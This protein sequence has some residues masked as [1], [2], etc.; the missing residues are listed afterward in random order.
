MWFT[1]AVPPGQSPEAVVSELSAQA[2]GLPAL[3]L[4]AVKKYKLA[5]VLDV[6]EEGDWEPQEEKAEAA[7]HRI[8]Y[9]L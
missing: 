8:G 3:V 4:P 2:G 5:V 6:L 9:E 1:I 7:P